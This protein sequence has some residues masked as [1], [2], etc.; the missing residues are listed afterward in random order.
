MKEMW[1]IFHFLQIPVQY[2]QKC[3]RYT[4]FAWSLIP[5]KMFAFTTVEGIERIFYLR[6]LFGHQCLL[7]MPRVKF[8]AKP[9]INVANHAA[10]T[11]FWFQCH[12]ESVEYFDEVKPLSKLWS[13]PNS[14]ERQFCI[15]SNYQLQK[16]TALYSISKVGQSKVLVKSWSSI[17]AHTK[18]HIKWAKGMLFI[19]CY[20]LQLKLSWRQ[21]FTMN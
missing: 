1:L 7:R 14:H 9:S 19:R 5:F 12:P 16:C 10:W 6:L 18:M 13:P 8:P 20:F 15:V 21:S 3:G 17:L 4:K 11:G 2:K